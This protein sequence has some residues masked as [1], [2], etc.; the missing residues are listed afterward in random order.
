M[1]MPPEL[2]SA[3]EEIATAHSLKN[4]SGHVQNV[5][6]RYRYQS[7][8]GNSLLSL[9]DEAV[10]YALYRMPATYGAISD[11]LQETFSRL[12]NLS[13]DSLLD[14]GAGTGAATWA[15]SQFLT[16]RNI[17]CLEKIPAMRA[18]GQKLMTV[19]GFI[20]A[21]QWISADMTQTDNIGSAD[22]VIA[23]YVLNELTENDRIKSLSS[24]WQAAR[25][26]LIL[27]EPGTPVCYRQMMQYRDWAV[28]NGGHIVAPCPHA[29]KCPLPEND[30]CHFAC[31]IARS[32]NHRLIKKAALG[33]E[34][35]KFCYLALSKEPS[36]SVCDRV[37]TP[38]QQH[39]GHV[40]LTVCQQNG[41][42]SRLTV[43]K[44]E[45]DLYKKA[46]KMKWGSSF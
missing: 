36:S 8:K 10:A 30:W 13:Y 2:Q 45:K 20:P 25:K 44:K 37:I 29:Q 39:G 6:N 33:Y 1:D 15:V 26:L 19:A 38:V 21:P 32:K 46:K 9:P 43:S 4:L 11:A 14:V 18:I 40:D 22:I 42:T 7:G 12:G 27:V 24:L 5:S 16:C 31:R 23:S 3:L 28:R 17:T 41:Q 34:D 35:E